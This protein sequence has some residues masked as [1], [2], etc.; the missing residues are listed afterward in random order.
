MSLDAIEQS[1]TPARKLRPSPQ[2]GELLTELK[3]IDI[4]NTD[5]ED[6]WEWLIFKRRSQR[7]RRIRN[8]FGL[9]G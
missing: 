1:G 6:G 9:D 8:G 2:S 4:N 3:S 7:N 5:L